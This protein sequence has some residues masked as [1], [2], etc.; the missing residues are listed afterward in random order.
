MG[1]LDS[2]PNVKHKPP[3]RTP[4]V[5]IY[6]IG[7][8]HNYAKCHDCDWEYSDHVNQALARRKIKKHVRETKHTV[9]LEKGIAFRYSPN[10]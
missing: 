10:Q 4:P 1:F 3:K 5:H 6:Y 2:S 8:V 9:T 7:I